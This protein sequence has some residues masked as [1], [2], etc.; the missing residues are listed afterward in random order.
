MN[1]TSTETVSGLKGKRYT[2]LLTIGVTAMFAYSVTYLFAVSPILIRVCGP[3]LA[4]G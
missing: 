2:L 3:M 4:G 1:T